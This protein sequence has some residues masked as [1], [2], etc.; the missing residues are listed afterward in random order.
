MIKY[1]LKLFVSAFSLR[2][3]SFFFQAT[4][5]L[6]LIYFDI[7]SVRSY[8]YFILILWIFGLLGALYSKLLS[9]RLIIVV[10]FVITI[11]MT[12]LLASGTKMLLLASIYIIF[13]MVSAFSARSGSSS[14]I[15]GS[16]HRG[17]TI[18]SAGL[19]F[20]L[21]AA[22]LAQLMFFNLKNFISLSLTIFALILLTAVFYP[23]EGRNATGKWN[24]SEIKKLLFSKDI[25]NSI[26]NS[27]AGSMAWPFAVSFLGVY[28]YKFLNFSLTMVSI[29][30]L[31][32]V[33]ISAIT[34]VVL[35]TLH[36]LPG[37]LVQKFSVLL[38]GISIL[39]GVIFRQPTVFIISMLFLGLAH[40][41]YSPLLLYGFL[42]NSSDKL[43][44]YLMYNASAGTSEILSSAIGGILI[45]QLNYIAGIMA[46]AIFFLLLNLIV[47]LI[48]STKGSVFNVAQK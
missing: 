15:E 10:S 13:M 11:I 9:S 18:Y 24:I 31:I 45:S 20:G 16:E 32:S 1:N 29:A 27:V 22:M 41:I 6:I 21:A 36:K 23:F 2:I 37:S 46:F 7:A 34:R 4:L 40:G 39:T 43:V 17:V 12:V 14:Y 8:W 48:E 19:A 26:I 3:I 30:F 5:P 25:L 44:G 38:Y 28:A 47:Y 33:L 42:K 35:Y